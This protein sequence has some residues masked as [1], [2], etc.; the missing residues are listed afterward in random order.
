M[1]LNNKKSTHRRPAFLASPLQ[2]SSEEDHLV[3]SPKSET[4]VPSVDDLKSEMKA[5]DGTPIV[6]VPKDYFNIV[7]ASFKAGLFGFDTESNIFNHR[8]RLIQI[9]DGRTVYIFDSIALNAD[10]ADN[11]LIRFLKSKN[12]I[13]VGVDI[14]TDADRLRHYIKSSPSTAKKDKDKF[15]VNGLID[16]QPLAASIG[17]TKLG[18]ENLGARFVKGFNSNPSDHGTYNP[19]TTEQYIYAANDAIVSLKIY[20]T[21]QVGLSL[22][23]GPKGC[24]AV[25]ELFDNHVDL[26]TG[27]QPSSIKAVVKQLAV[28]NPSWQHLPAERKNI[29]AF[30][31]IADMAARNYFTHFNLEEDVMWVSPQ[32]WPPATVIEPV[33]PQTVPKKK[34][35][36]PKKKSTT[37]HDGVHLIN[38]QTGAH[39]D[40]RF[41]ANMTTL[42]K[43]EH[44]LNQVAQLNYLID[45]LEVRPIRK[46]Q[47]VDHYFDLIRSTL[48]VKKAKDPQEVD[49]LISRLTQSQSVLTDLLYKEIWLKT[50]A[51]IMEYTRLDMVF[52]YAGFVKIV[53]ANLVI[54]HPELEIDHQHVFVANVFVPYAIQTGHLIVLAGGEDKCMLPKPPTKE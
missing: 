28:A 42:E 24:N 7:A 37:D 9:Y 47:L 6:I 14:Q 49:R 31:A 10:Y 25:D 43:S 38:A 13:K 44:I 8:L 52:T 40:M 22:T 27:D 17:E 36:K 30:K 32:S 26:W 5:Y 35:K 41:G 15:T 53:S 39:F 54:L 48:A 1:D 11:A 3:L 12:R 20:E 4:P 21:F 19:P 50:L 33:E 45:L 51:S 46:G 34:K 18:L 16:V 29:M 23:A 2:S